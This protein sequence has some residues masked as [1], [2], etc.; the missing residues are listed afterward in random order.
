MVKS[1]HSGFILALTNY[2][3]LDNGIKPSVPYFP[4]PLNGDINS[5]HS[6]RVM[7]SNEVL[8]SSA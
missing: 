3:T 8:K 6:K 5:A 4:L 7:L 1:K 2:G